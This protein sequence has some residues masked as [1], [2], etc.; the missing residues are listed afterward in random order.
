VKESLLSFC[1]D[2]IGEEPVRRFFPHVQMHEFEGLLFSDAKIFASA[3]NKSYLSRDF[4][5]I[6][7]VFSTPED[8]DDGYETAPSKRI[9]AVY[10]GYK[11]IL[12]GALAAEAIGL[13]TIRREC[14]LFDSWVSRIESL[15]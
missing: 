12:H 5:A 14:R 8:I 1:A 10:R 9:A 6:R 13:A 2:K 4:E 11:K 3:I 15:Q 7:T